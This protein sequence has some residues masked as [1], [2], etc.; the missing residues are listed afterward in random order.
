MTRKSL[1][2]SGKLYLLLQKSKS[3]NKIKSMDAI[4]ELIQQAGQIL[5]IPLTLNS[6]RRCVVKSPGGKFLLEA[7]IQSQVVFLYS[8]LG[9]LPQYGDIGLL[10]KT[11]L[12]W[13][14]FGIKMHGANFCF[15]PVSTQV[16]L[17]K[18]FPIAVLTP[19]LLA[20]CIS[21]FISVV[22]QMQDEFQ[23][24]TERCLHVQ[25][26]NNHTSSQGN[27]RDNPSLGRN[28]RIIPI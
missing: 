26:N 28:F 14:L 8:S 27:N 9:R 17:Y 23:H 12:Q 7:P 5:K 2:I 6:R 21:N 4:A 3:P 22:G 24:L 1:R 20:N 13:N 18:D 19:Q 10:L 16:L 15:D 25:K 11:L